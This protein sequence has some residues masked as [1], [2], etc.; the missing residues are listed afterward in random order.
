MLC[1]FGDVGVI[2]KDVFGAFGNLVAFVGGCWGC[3]VGVGGALRGVG[4][5]W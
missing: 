4:G 5:V 2:L 1:R 3:F